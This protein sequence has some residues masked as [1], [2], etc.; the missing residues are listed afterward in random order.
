M[1][2]S[3]CLSVAVITCPPPPATHRPVM[4]GYANT[5]HIVI[6][7]TSLRNGFKVLETQIFII[8]HKSVKLLSSERH[9]SLY[10]ILFSPVISSHVR[11]INVHLSEG[12]NQPENCSEYLDS[13]ETLLS[14]SLQLADDVTVTR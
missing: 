1:V 12:I 2:L 3:Q 9:T 10:S 4:T 13:L 11:N 5:L 14:N 8:P 6:S 7:L